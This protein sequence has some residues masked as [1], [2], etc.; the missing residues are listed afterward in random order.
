MNHQSVTTIRKQPYWVLTGFIAILVIMLTA[1]SISL[2]SLSAL[3]Q[4]LEHLVKKHNVK[5]QYMGTMRDLIRERM[6]KVLVALNLEDPFKV[7][8]EWEAFSQRAR[9]FIS[10][11]EKLEKLD[12]TFEEKSRID[13][14]RRVLSEGQEVMA[15][16]FDLIREGNYPQA[17]NDIFKALKANEAIIE[18]LTLM[19]KVGHDVSK[20]ELSEAT[21]NYLQ[22]RRNVFVL[23]VSAVLT[24]L[25][26]AIVIFRNLRINQKNLTDAVDALKQANE[27]LEAR[28]LERTQDL[29]VL[30]DEA[31]N[32]NKAKSRFLANMS[33]E[34]RTP[35]NAIIGYSDILIEDAEENGL[36]EECKDLHKILAAGKHLLDLIDDILDISRIESDNLEV[37]WEQF[38]LKELVQ[39]VVDVM[40]PLI[41]QRNNQFSFDYDE[42]IVK[43]YA[44]PRRLK[45][46][47]FNLLSNANKFTDHGQIYLDIN[48]QVV[49]NKLWLK[50]EI[51]DTG[52][53]I[54]QEDQKKVFQIFMQVD[55]SATRK[56]G[57]TGLGLAIS[58]RF[59]QMMGGTIELQ[60]ELG[61][62]CCVTV[63]LP[64]NAETK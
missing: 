28:V 27:K 63:L 25:I 4:R 13:I 56:Y 22:T 51:K 43:A 23:D 46:V 11:R 45:Q 24:C 6:L 31:V 48:Q 32:A 20:K 53:G 19:I 57:G 47:L 50:C 35:L 44:D 8:E 38:A 3:N 62:G 40:H 9:E 33:H 61:K 64:L 54:S 30:R 10:T 42:Q 12:V 60:S 58:L 39:E 1:T 2:T 29:L 52:I 21:D 16:V 18:E 14:Q 17:R 37:E 59:C 36:V 41:E 49:N 7:E 26:I 34:L 5:L 55:A 15:Q